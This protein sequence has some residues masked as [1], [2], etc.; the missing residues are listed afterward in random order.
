MSKTA[1]IVDDSRLGRMMVKRTIAQVHPDWVYT[2]AA[3]ATEV[4]EN[5]DIGQFD[6]IFVDVNMPGMDGLELTDRLRQSHPELPIALVTANIQAK[7]QK[8]GD[9]LG[10][11]VI[12]KPLTAEKLSRWLETVDA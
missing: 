12:D 6:F 1:L 3:T 2:E 8:H 10:I 4:L 11:R 7:V 5:V 9:R